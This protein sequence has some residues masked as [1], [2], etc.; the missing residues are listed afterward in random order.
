MPRRFMP[1]R[2]LPVLLLTTLLGPLTAAAGA[3]AQELP[4]AADNAQGAGRAVPA[5]TSKDGRVSVTRSDGSTGSMRQPDAKEIR[6]LAG[7]MRD[8]MARADR[9]ET[10]RQTRKTIQYRRDNRSRR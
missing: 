3:G 5:A 10:H 4:A 6:K 8:G 7:Y 1:R 9:S 2:L